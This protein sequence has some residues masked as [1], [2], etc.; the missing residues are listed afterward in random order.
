[1][2]TKEITIQHTPHARKL[3]IWLFL[4]TGFVFVM[5][6]LGGITRLSH[7]GL[8]IVEWKPLLGIL[9]PLSETDWNEV[10]VKYQSFPEYQKRNVGMTLAEFQPIFWLEYIHRLWGRLIG[11][12]FLLPFLYFW[13]CGTINRRLAQKLLGV[14]FLGALQGY[15]GWYMVKSGL[16]D[17]PDVS[18]Y[19]LAAHFALALFIFALLFR[20]SLGLL[21]PSKDACPLAFFRCVTRGVLLLIFFTAIA[22]SFVA[23]IDAGLTY[24]TFPRM[25]DGFIPEDYWAL[26]PPWRNF[27]ENI[28]SVQFNHRLLGIASLLGAGAL[29]LASFR[30]T[31]SRR[32]CLVFTCLFGITIL[33]VALGIATLLL[34]VPLPLGIAHQAG[35]ILIFTF[36]LWADYEIRQM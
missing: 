9:P 36:A 33:Q 23:G 25:G 32:A 26:E 19:R 13:Y 7:A 15:L 29:W 14:F 28:A 6:L 24:N 27:F 5:I 10:F 21:Y 35:A 20:L 18:P 4:C 16:G 8:S 1:M 22:G 31:L 17:R 3:T 2:I 11:V 30:T 34:I 12:V